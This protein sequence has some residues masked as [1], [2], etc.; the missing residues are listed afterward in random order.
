MASSGENRW[1]KLQEALN[2]GCLDEIGAAFAATLWT[3]TEEVPRRR[4]ANLAPVE[5]RLADGGMTPLD[6]NMMLL[7]LCE[8]GLSNDPDLEFVEKGVSV[9]AAELLLR[10]G[11]DP[12]FQLESAHGKVK[13]PM[14]ALAINDQSDD[15]DNW[16][17]EDVQVK[18]AKVLL[19][20]GADPCFGGPRDDAIS[21]AA[22]MQKSQL[23]LAMAEKSGD[24]DRAR[25]A[26]QAYLHAD[27]SD[28]DD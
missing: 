24:A 25:A 23:H 5:Q 10:Y 6:I 2:E 13:T 28:Y 14:M 9:C 21:W 7:G 19:E 8:A 26:L 1:L 15:E 11:A 20:A 27:D 22:T 3:R 18:V 12:N 4:I 16:V 17:M